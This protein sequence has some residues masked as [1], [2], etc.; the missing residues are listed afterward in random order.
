MKT[1]LPSLEISTALNERDLLIA[2][3]LQTQAL[4]ASIY[5]MYKHLQANPA[6][7]QAK[8]FDDLYAECWVAAHQDIQSTLTKMASDKKKSGEA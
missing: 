4:H 7:P 5:V 8:D 6:W 1:V 3:L 2:L